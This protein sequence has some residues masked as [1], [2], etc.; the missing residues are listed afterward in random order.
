ML[1]NFNFIQQKFIFCRS[2]VSCSNPFKAN[3]IKG[4]IHPLAPPINQIQSQSKDNTSSLNPHPTISSSFDPSSSIL[5]DHQSSIKIDHINHLNQQINLTHNLDLSLTISSNSLKIFNLNL[6]YLWLR[7]SCQSENSVDPLTKQK[8]FKSSDIPLR[9]HPIKTCL[10]K[11]PKTQQIELTIH[12]SHNLPQRS[13]NSSLTLRQ[14]QTSTFEL[15]FLENAVN[16]KQWERY[17]HKSQTLQQNLWFEPNTTSQTNLIEYSKTENDL[18]IDYHQFLS[19]KILQQKALMKLNRYG[20]I[21][22]DKL[23]TDEFELKKLIQTLGVETRRT[24]YGDFWDVKSEGKDAKNIANT[25]MELDLHMDL[26]HFQNPPRFQLLHCL[27]N[28][29]LGGASA[30]VDTYSVLSFLLLDSPELFC[31]LA[32]ELV[33]FEYINNQHHTYFCHPTVQLRSGV[34]PQSITKSPNRLL[35][36]IVAVNYSPPFQGPLIPGGRLSDLIKGLEAFDKLCKRPEMRFEHQLKEGQCVA[37]D[38]R[39]ILHARTAFKALENSTL[40]DGGSSGIRRWLKGAYVEGDS[41]WDRLRVLYATQV[42]SNK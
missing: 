11:N 25:S 24:F 19:D 2:Y 22:F 6:P 16:P 34:T 9:I 10:S 17:R 40:N 5:A 21:F 41:V 8:L 28:Q 39:R 4:P 42:F 36:S 35:E 12:W 13:S 30:F 23:G 20:L 32:S 3:I 31:T 29:V 33:P 38:N 37:F 14:P 15:S 27:K 1:K 26:V 18:F 7:D